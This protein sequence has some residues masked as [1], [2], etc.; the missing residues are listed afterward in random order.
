MNYFL[1]GIQLFRNKTISSRQFFIH[2]NSAYLQSQ[3]TNMRA[4]L[5]FLF[6]AAFFHGHS[7]SKSYSFVFLNK[8][9]DAEPMAKEKVDEIMKGH[10]ANIERLAKEGKLIAAGPFE[11]G[12]GIFILNT[13]DT[14]EAKK[15]LS[16]DPGV[17]A[18][19]WNI[20]I[21]PYTPRIGSVCVA[22]EPYEMVSYHSIRFRVTS[23]TS[24]ENTDE[25]QKE[26]EKYLNTQVEKGNVITEGTF[27]AHGNILIVKEPLD[28]KLIASDP[29]IQKGI[30]SADNKILWIAK[31]SF[32]EK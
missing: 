13:T 32:C 24:I 14:D 27:G 15:W 31:G 28:A 16:T 3:F 7:Q 11:G 20:E 30:V 2:K 1:L 6:L 26:H 22:K 9:S 25:I 12:G 29:A 23:G 18:N 21:L 17:Q 5:F 8:K 19:R 4:T 10:M